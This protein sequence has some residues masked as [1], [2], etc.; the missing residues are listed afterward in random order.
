MY[1]GDISNQTWRTELNSKN[2]CYG[3][4]DC[5]LN[6]GKL[7]RRRNWRKCCSMCLLM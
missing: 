5:R 2:L 1:D 7:H 3:W 4:T 6:D